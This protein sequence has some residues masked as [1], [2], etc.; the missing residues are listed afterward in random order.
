M[1]KFIVVDV[2]L[3]LVFVACLAAIIVVIFWKDISLWRFWLAN[4]RK[5]GDKKWKDKQ[6]QQGQN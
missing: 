4:R 6:S 2:F 3:F 5:G 1:S